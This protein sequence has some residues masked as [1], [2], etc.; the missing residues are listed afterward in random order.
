ILECKRYSTQNTTMAGLGEGLNDY[1]DEIGYILG[2]PD[3]ATKAP[4]NHTGSNIHEYST[5]APGMVKSPNTLDYGD[6]AGI[7]SGCIVTIVILSLIIFTIHR[8]AK[9]RTPQIPQDDDCDIPFEKI[10]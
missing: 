6:M 8:I 1:I 7:T 5:V 10:I 3:G 2:T 4:L 9:R